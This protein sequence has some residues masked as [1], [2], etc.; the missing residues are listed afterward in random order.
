MNFYKHH[1][2]DYDGATVHLSWDE[3][4]AY[5]RLLRVYYRL[6]KPIPLA[7]ADTYRLVRA[8]TKAQK[9]AVTRVLHEYF[10]EQADG[11]HNKR[12]DEEIAAYQAQAETNRRIARARTVERT[13]NESSTRAN[14]I[15]RTKRARNVD[16]TTNHKP[17]TTNQEPENQEALRALSG[18]QPDDSPKNGNV[19]QRNKELRAQAIEILK[20]LNEKA[21]RN[22][23]TA[24]ATNVDPVVV[25]LREG[26]TPE[27][28]R[29]VIAN[30]VRKWKGDPQMNEY[31]RPKTLFRRSNFENYKGE[32]P[33]AEQP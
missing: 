1:L 7:P 26:K 14:T 19:Y 29:A 30:R 2:G 16:L 32:I 4:L 33:P 23:D 3:D 15:R 6:E 10:E 9:E 21:E 13:D 31:L 20:F 12:C 11:W 17:E 5:T 28:V 25:L 27:D 8:G 24:V 22:F 18:S